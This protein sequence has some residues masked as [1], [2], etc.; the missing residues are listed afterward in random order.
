M[1]GRDQMQSSRLH[2]RLVH[3]QRNILKF[4]S[5]LCKRDGDLRELRFQ[6]RRSDR[7]PDRLF[8]S[9]GKDDHL[10]AFQLVGILARFPSEMELF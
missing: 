2:H 4:K 10:G 7:H 5:P 9:V 6:L 3:T 8:M 1:P